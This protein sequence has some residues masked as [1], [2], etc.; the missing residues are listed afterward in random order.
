MSTKKE[1][2]TNKVKVFVV[3]QAPLICNL[4]AVVLKQESDIHVVGTTTS[5]DEAIKS[6]SKCDIMLVDADLPNDGALTLSQEIGRKR[7]NTN[8]LIT[9][10]EKTPQTILKYMEAGASGYILKEFTVEKLVEQ[11]RLLPEGKAM[12]DPEVIAGLIER[13]SELANLCGDQETLQ[14]GLDSLS[15][16]EKEVLDLLSEGESNADI[17]EELHIEVG[18]VKNHV[19]SILKKLGVSNRQ[20]AAKMYEQ[21]QEEEE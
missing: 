3:N 13:L 15:P 5:V 14:R 2:E 19:H 6:A 1:V 9:G 7:P 16:R 18:T 8:I 10:M 21:S 4:L 20:Q 17:S 11:I 12:A